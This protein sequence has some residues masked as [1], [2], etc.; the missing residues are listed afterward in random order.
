SGTT[1]ARHNHDITGGQTAV[2]HPTN[3]RPPR[4][5]L[6]QRI[7]ERNQ[8]LEEFTEA[9]ETYAR[10]HEEP[11]TLSLRHLQRLITGKR[12][13]GRPL[14]TLRPATARLLERMLGEPI[15]RLLSEPHNDPERDG[16]E[17]R[18]RI[19]TARRIDGSLIALL[20]EQ[21]N[22]IRRIDRELGAIVAHDEVK[23]KIHQVQ[24]LLSYSLMPHTRQQLAALL[25]EL[26]TLAGWQALD[27]GNIS[28][29][30]QHYQAAQIVA[31]ASESPSYEAHAAAEQAFVLV[32]IGEHQAAV[33]LA[34]SACD[35]A[36][37]R[38]SY[39]LRAWLEAARGET[40][41]AL[42][43]AD[44]SLQ[45]FD[46]AAEHLSESIPGEQTGPY[47]ALDFVHLDRWRGHA[48]VRLRHDEAIDVLEQVEPELDSTFSRAESALQADLATAYASIGEKDVAEKHLHR[49]RA[50]AERISSKRQ[51]RRMIALDIA[52]G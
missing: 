48:L 15:D 47:V 50:I 2:T 12:P 41:S 36:R 10:E 43:R 32:D 24:Q 9:A 33:D 6:E 4:T 3:G 29:A 22:A 5:L 11:G 44:S 28:D 1:R 18:A 40:L 39:L 37:N 42:N 49:G 20:H 19:A 38:S 51:I 14:G 27:L 8:T 45:A 16:D 30:W 34:S 31:A 17:L 23:T 25:S 26:G 46:F 35:R 52:R 13:D 7:R 21:L